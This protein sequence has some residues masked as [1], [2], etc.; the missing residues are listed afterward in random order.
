ML[1]NCWISCFAFFSPIEGTPGI[2]SEESPQCPNMSITCEGVVI[3]KRCHTSS[4]PHIS[5]GFAPLPSFNILIFS[6]TNCA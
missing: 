1:E 4:T 5:F 3:S 6:S 2:L